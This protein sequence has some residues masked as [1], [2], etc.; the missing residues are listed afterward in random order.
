MLFLRRCLWRC[1][2]I[3]ELLD[4]IRVDPLEEDGKLGARFLLPARGSGYLLS[5]FTVATFE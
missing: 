1:G 3:G 2:R 4:H 5:V